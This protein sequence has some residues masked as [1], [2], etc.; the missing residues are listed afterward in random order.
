MGAFTFGVASALVVFQ[1]TLVL[2]QLEQSTWSFSL[3][4]AH[5][6]ASKW[7]PRPF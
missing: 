3:A 5:P 6:D 4:I 7:E 2:L 1:C